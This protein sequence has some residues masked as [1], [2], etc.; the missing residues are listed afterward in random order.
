M[1]KPKCI[2]D[3]N[4]AKKGVDLSDQMSSYYTV[5]RK[6]SK[7]YRKTAFE[8][9][10]GAVIVNSHIVFNEINTSSRN[11]TMREFREKLAFALTGVN[12][13]NQNTTN[14]P[15][16]I[17]TFQTEQGPGRKRRRNCTECYKKLRVTLTS[18]EADKK[19]TKVSTFCGDCDKKPAM[20]LSCFN[21]KHSS[22]SK[23]QN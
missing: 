23:T 10:F 22:L 1:L 13:I 5:L 8:L 12:Q 21:E 20:C 19:V 18:R 11:L 3:Y 2:I 14:T 15:K 4:H 17:H 6:G 16:R 7:W 9:L